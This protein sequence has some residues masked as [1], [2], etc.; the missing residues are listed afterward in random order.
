[1]MN[2]DF[3]NNDYLPGVYNYCDRWC[4]RCIFNSRCMVNATEEQVKESLPI[5]KRDDNL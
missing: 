4:G 3:E 1:M 5:D 2:F